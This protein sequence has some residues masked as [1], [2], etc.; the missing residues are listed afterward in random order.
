MADRSAIEWTDATCNP[1]R[2]TRT[3]GQLMQQLRYGWHCEHVSEGCR[4]CYAEGFNRRL[5]TGLDYKP[6][7]R[8]DIA[9]FLDE[10]MLLQPLRWRKPR[11]IFVCSMTDLFADFVPDEWIDKM[12]AVMAL[13]PQHIFQVLTKRPERM[14]RCLVDSPSDNPLDGR[15]Q[16]VQ[17][18][19]YRIMAT[20]DG[21]WNEDRAMAARQ[22]VIDALL[23]ISDR[24]NAGFKNVWLGV[25]VE[26]QD[27]ADV[28]IPLLLRTPAAARWLSCEPLLGPVDLTRIRR[29]PDI[30]GEFINAIAGKMWTDQT[31]LPNPDPRWAYPGTPFA[32]GERGI[33][34]VVVGGESGPKARPMHPDWA[35]SLRDQCAAAGV[36]LHFKQWGNWAPLDALRLD[37]ARAAGD[38]PISDSKGHVRDWMNRYVTFEG[39]AGAIRVR[40]HAFSGHSTNLVYNVGKKAAGRLLDDVLHDGAPA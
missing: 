11:K 33:D 8:R 25:S 40:G 9:L 29:F 16:R 24:E 27:A 34:W 7:Y 36:P 19:A 37:G 13:C 6:G 1:I 30:T 14:L 17:G 5:G 35:R 21:K 2:A 22:A 3:T 15:L 20:I 31:G 10:K 38:Y 26:D 12:F 4:N 23:R 18:A 39:D 28:R 32:D